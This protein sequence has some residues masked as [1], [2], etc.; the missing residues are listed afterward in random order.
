RPLPVNSTI[1]VRPRSALG[2]KYVQ[3]TE[4]NSKKGFQD[5]DT[6][7][8]KNSTPHPVEIDQVFNTFD[9]KTRRAQQV[10]LREFGNGLAGRGGDLNVAISDLPRLLADLQPVMRM[11]SDRSTRLD[12]FFR[13]LERSASQVAPVAE[14]QGQ[15]FV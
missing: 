15:L 5:G 6:I 9:A 7:P 1:I 11:L 2:L 10:N 12:N 4:G 8:L 14:T 13:A 3:I